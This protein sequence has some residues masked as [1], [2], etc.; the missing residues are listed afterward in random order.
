M[1]NFLMKVAC[2]LLKNYVLLEVSCKNVLVA[3]TKNA[4]GPCDVTRRSSSI[5]ADSFKCKL[6]GTMYTFYRYAYKI[7]NLLI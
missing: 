5:C 2:F 6:F 3:C 1:V 4:M 7:N